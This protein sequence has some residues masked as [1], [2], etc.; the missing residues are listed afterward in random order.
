MRM[1]H[2]LCPP[3]GAASQAGWN[4]S[5]NPLTFNLHKQTPTQGNT[6]SYAHPN[7]YK[8]TFIKLLID[9]HT[10]ASFYI[11]RLH[12][13]HTQIY[14]THIQAH[15]ILHTHINVHTYSEQLAYTNSE[16]FIFKQIKCN[17]H[18]LLSLYLSLLS[19]SLSPLNL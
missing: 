10:L 1:Y 12:L 9:S 8:H 3:P 19:L 13:T 11:Q 7:T 2:L 5:F 17:K 16:H 15:I 14:Y 4:L 6:Q 18:I